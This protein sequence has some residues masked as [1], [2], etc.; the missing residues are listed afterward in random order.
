[1]KDGGGNW[2]KSVQDIGE[3]AVQEWEPGV[4][5][6]NSWKLTLQQRWQGKR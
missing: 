4:G 2:T 6:G 5:M 3:D 1:M